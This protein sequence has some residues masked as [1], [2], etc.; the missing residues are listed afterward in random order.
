MLY[1]NNYYTDAATCIELFSI[2]SKYSKLRLFAVSEPACYTDGRA[3]WADAIFVA[4]N[5]DLD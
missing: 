1:E 4:S 5:I 3:I 2:V